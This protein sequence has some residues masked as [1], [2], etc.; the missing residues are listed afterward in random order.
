MIL[1]RN[2]FLIFY[3]G[4]LRIGQYILEIVN[5]LTEASVREQ[6]EIDEG[7]HTLEI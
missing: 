4:G 1:R 6:G 7:C 2:F 5:L 3:A